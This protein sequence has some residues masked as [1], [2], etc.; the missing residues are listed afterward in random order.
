MSKE[1]KRIKDLI[2]F[3]KQHPSLYNRKSNLYNCYKRKQ[4]KWFLIFF[5]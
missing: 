2:K 5:K 1:K 4:S 3:V